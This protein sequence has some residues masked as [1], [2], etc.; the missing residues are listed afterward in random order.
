MNQF[1]IWTGRVVP[2]MN[3]NIDTDQLLPKQ[4]LKLIDKKGFGKYLFY[5]WRYL[6]DDYTANPDFILNQSVYQ[7]TSILISGDNFGS[8]SSREHA[9]WAIA[10][11]G[12][13]VIIAGSF[14]DIFYNNAL[15]N[16][17]LPI[18]QPSSIREVL[19]NLT[20]DQ[21]ITIDLPEEL[22]RTPVGNFPF[23]IEPEWKDKL[24]NG[25]D[26]IGMTLTFE[27]LI[28]QYEQKRPIYWQNG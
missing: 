11:Y 24:L 12:F 7:G 13:K 22:I 9:A 14:G 17:I 27:E 5:T 21:E 19:V 4:F 26:D 8:G 10:D 20:P 16:G 23:T 6:D 3:D 15:N 25:L 18:V 28:H 1:T 2:L